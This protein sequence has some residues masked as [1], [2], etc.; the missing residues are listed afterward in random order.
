MGTSSTPAPST[1]AT[2]VPSDHRRALKDS[3]APTVVLL[4]AVIVLVTGS[5]LIDSSD[6]Q[7]DPASWG[8]L[9]GTGLTV[10]FLGPWPLLATLILGVV[11]SV[12]RTETTARWSAAARAVV[13]AC[14]GAGLLWAAAAWAVGP[15]SPAGHAFTGV[16]FVA[17]VPTLLPIVGRLH[18][19]HR[20]RRG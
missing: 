16:L 12:A 7:Q 20:R 15:T 18:A 10:A 3:W 1:G 11:G 9:L 19:A 14:C 2:S 4:T 8:Y 6:L 17:A 5:W 13:A